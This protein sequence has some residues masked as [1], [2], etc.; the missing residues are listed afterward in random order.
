MND[1]QSIAETLASAL[2]DV[3][4]LQHGMFTPPQ[5]RELC[6]KTIL[7]RL[8]GTHVKMRHVE[9]GETVQDGDLIKQRFILDLK[10]PVRIYG[11][12]S[13]V[14]KTQYCHKGQY[15]RPIQS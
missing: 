3:S 15:F 4:A 2:W 1:N 12:P 6:E 9:E 14:G 11:E 8:N 7:D 5:F 13:V 10:W